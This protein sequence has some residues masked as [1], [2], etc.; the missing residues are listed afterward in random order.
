MD[1]IQGPRRWRSRGL[2][3]IV[4]L[5]LV[6]Q[7]AVGWAQNDEDRA[8]ARALAT[9]G[10]KAYNEGRWAAAIELFSRAQSLVHA[11][12]QEL[13]LARA[14]A[15][16][17]QLVSAREVY[18]KITREP[19]DANAPRA[20][21]NAK[22]TAQKEL[23]AIG[24]RLPY[25]SVVVQGAG[26]LPV[27]VT[28]DGQTVP[29]ALVGVP[30]PVDPG[31]HK[32]QAH[33]EGMKT[34]ESTV[35]VAEGG[36]ETV[37]LTLQPARK[38]PGDTAAPPVAS[39]PSPPEDKSAP[40]ATGTTSTA[41]APPARDAGGRSSNA[42]RYGAYGA[43]GVG[44]AGLVVGTVFTLKASSKR[45]QADSLCNQPG[46]ACPEAKKSQVLALDSDA[47]SAG[48]IGVVGFVVGGVG[49]GAGVALLLLSI[50]SDKSEK[51]ASA[52]MISPW[53][54]FR[55]AGVSGQF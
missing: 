5:A 28:M 15:K 4:V 39:S 8:G 7:S 1:G 40:P 6:G 17:G 49:V 31:Q 13:Y 3:A 27:T 9:Q 16:L 52:P 29:Q 55:S 53:L 19:L 23:A 33:A 12:P 43:F 25:I 38:K 36:R 21:R 10:L 48:K 44:A 51:A 32:F 20:F 14:H 54:G 45:S 47:N 50:K 22:A 37:V 26:P 35:T 2:A 41:V 42:M 11:P 30:R 18:I 34:N 24:P 46:G